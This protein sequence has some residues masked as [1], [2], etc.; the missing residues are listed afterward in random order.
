MD[1]NLMTA[2]PEQ[3]AAFKYGAAMQYKARGVG[4][5]DADALFESGVAKLAESLGAAAP[6]NEKAE[7][8]AAAMRATLAGK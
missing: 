8:L 2:T 1:A 7:K 4:P 5:T 6:R 3:I